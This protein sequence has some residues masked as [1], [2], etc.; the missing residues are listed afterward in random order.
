M[1]SPNLKITITGACA[2]G[3]TGLSVAIFHLLKEH[4]IDVALHHSALDGK[5]S[6]TQAANERRLRYV[7]NSG[8]TVVI[9]NVTSRRH[10]DPIESFNPDALIGWLEA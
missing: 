2:S 1:T 9:E 6:G 10:E 5:E 8:G 7:A 3:K 4:G